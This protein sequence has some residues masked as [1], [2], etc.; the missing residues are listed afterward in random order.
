MFRAATNPQPLTTQFEKPVRPLS[1]PAA[2]ISNQFQL[3]RRQANYSAVQPTGRVGQQI[4]RKCEKCENVVPVNRKETSDATNAAGGDVEDVLRS[5]GRLLDTATRNF[6]EPCFGH[7][8]RNVRIHTDDKAAQS[9]QALSA[10][11]YTVGQ[12]IVFGAGRHS[13]DTDQGRRLLAHELTHVVQQTGMGSVNPQSSI[14][15]RTQIQRDSKDKPST[16]P[17]KPRK[18]GNKKGADLCDKKPFKSKTLLAAK[19]EAL[20]R[21]KST[22]DGKDSCIKDEK[23]RDFVIDA[24]YTLTI[25]CVDSSGLSAEQ[26]AD[27]P[28]GQV[29][30]E[31]VDTE[32]GKS[33]TRYS[34]TDIDVYSAAIVDH[35]GCGDLASTILHEVVHLVE[36][37]RLSKGHSHLPYDCEQACFGGPRGKAEGCKLDSSVLRVGGRQ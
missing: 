11:A 34:G 4:N 12:N 37:R 36:G 18:G 17:S 35:E 15:S 23:L 6:M 21:V 14:A 26:T 2:G 32:S 27:D 24:F 16:E 19:A 28:C 9:A 10:H 8:F 33:E 3:R 29:H 25:I 1:K 30:K 22:G 20:K 7:D 31:I 13:P 5:P